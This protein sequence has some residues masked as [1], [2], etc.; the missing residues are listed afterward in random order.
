MT[1]ETL[2]KILSEKSM[3][4]SEKEINEMLDAELEKALRKWTRIS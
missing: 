2:I 3:P 1:K 4:F